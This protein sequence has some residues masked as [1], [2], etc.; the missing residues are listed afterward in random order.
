MRP[1]KPRSILTADDVFGLAQRVIGGIRINAALQPFGMS[2]A[3]VG[4]FSAT[5]GA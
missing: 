3:A 5:R 4:G 1:L 2:G